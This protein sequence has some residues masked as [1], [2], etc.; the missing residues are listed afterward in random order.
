MKNTLCWYGEVEMQIK[1]EST[2][3]CGASLKDIESFSLDQDLKQNGWCLHP[4]FFEAE[5]LADSEK[6]K[7]RRY[8]QKKR[9]S[10]GGDCG[11]IEKVGDKTYRICFKEKEGKKPCWVQMHYK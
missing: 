6:E 11:M 8:F 10:G 9:H 4:V 5:E 3:H 7:I 2:F 1:G